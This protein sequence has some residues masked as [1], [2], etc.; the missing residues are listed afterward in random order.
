MARRFSALITRSLCLLTLASSAFAQ[1][2][3]AEINGTV[4]DQEKGVLPGVMITVTDEKT[5]LT[6]TGVTSGDGRFVITTLTPGSYT[7]KADLAGFQSTV[8]TGVVLSVGQELT[9]N[10]TLQIEW[11]R[12][13]SY[14]HRP[15]AAG[16]VTSSRVGANITNAEIDSLPQP[17]PKPVEPDAA[18]AGLTP[19]LTRVRSK[20]ASST[21]TARR[22]PPIC[23]SSTAPTTTTTAAAAR[24]AH[25]R[26]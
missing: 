25:R 17:G 10:L 19:S 5:G 6:R 1:G 13:G 14:R 21:P 11:R 2:G 8:Q 7:I 4:I 12:G 26:A 3:R 18:G 23:S 20:A 9:L 22:R 24:R 16:R 15:V